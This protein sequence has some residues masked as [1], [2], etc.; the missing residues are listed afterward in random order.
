MGIVEIETAS[1]AQLKGI[2]T[3][4]AGIRESEMGI[5]DNSEGIMVGNGGSVCVD[6]VTEEDG[7]IIGGFV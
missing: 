4:V 6:I 1:S 2:E 3:M 7:G 5:D